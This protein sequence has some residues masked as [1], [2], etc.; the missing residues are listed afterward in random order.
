[1]RQT[2]SRI[3]THQP[4]QVLCI[5]A[6]G[7]EITVVKT[8]FYSEPGKIAQA[9]LARV[10][11]GTAGGRASRIAGGTMLAEAAGFVAWDELTDEQAQDFNSAASIMM[12][13]MCAD[14][15]AKA[16][17]LERGVECGKLDLAGRAEILSAAMS[18]LGHV[19]AEAHAKA[20]RPKR[21][22]EW[23]SWILRGEQSWCQRT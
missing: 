16:L 18:E 12:G 23:G 14:T 8:A 9:Q 19:G 20:L 5:G 11:M 6:G 10:L 4:T 21:R 7:G 3:T 2:D 13:Q 17:A 15:H 22:V 1:L